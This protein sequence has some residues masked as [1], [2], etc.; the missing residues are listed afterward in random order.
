M[1]VSGEKLLKNSVYASVNIYC[2]SMRPIE[3]SRLLDID[4]DSHIEKGHKTPG[5]SI[6]PHNSW[7]F[8]SKSRI[9]SSDLNDHLQYLVDKF[10]GKETQLNEILTQSESWSR[11]LCYWESQTG[12]GGPSIKKKTLAALSGLPFDL[13]FDIWF[14][15][16][17]TD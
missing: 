14:V 10:S 3:I 7:V 2:N 15:D 16:A 17:P 6:A 8:S 11:I 13:D 4:A 12:N 9:S 1:R 5:G